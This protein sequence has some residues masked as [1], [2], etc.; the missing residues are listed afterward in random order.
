MLALLIYSVK[1]S[2][3]K[4]CNVHP[5]FLPQQREGLHW[6][7]GMCDINLRGLMIR[8]P[9]K[10]FSFTDHSIFSLSKL[11]AEHDEGRAEITWR[12]REGQE[13]RK[14]WFHMLAEP[15]SIS[16]GFPHGYT[17]QSVKKDIGSLKSPAF[18][19]HASLKSMP[20]TL[21]SYI[22]YIGAV[23]ADIHCRYISVITRTMWMLNWK[24][25]WCVY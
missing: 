12:S 5:I 25:V 4:S 1:K 2:R 11:L 24:L 21:L 14:T 6:F 19:S 18:L 10:A 16:F 9:P 22:K 20:H 3:G 13:G 23:F 7:P 15:S 17:A 8:D